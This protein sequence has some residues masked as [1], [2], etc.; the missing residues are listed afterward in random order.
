MTMALQTLKETTK[1]E[2]K[3]EGKNHQHDPGDV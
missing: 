3:I 2:L 1:G